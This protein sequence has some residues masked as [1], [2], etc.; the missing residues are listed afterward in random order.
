MNL[1]Q[2]RG[3]NIAA[4]AIANKDAPI[5]RALLTNDAEYRKAA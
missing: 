4:V 3:K 5:A 2:C 1:A